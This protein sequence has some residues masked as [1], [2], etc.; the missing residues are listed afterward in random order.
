MILGF[1]TATKYCSVALY[2][3]GV[4]FEQTD[5]APNGHAAQLMPMIDALLTQ[6]KAGLSDIETIVV[7][8]GPGSFTGLRI[9]I[10]T[11]L[12]LASSLQVPLVGVSSLKAR[13]FLDQPT[14]CPLI[15]ARRDRVYA[16]CFGEFE[17]PEANLPFSEL[18]ELIQ[19]REVVF[20]GED[21]ASFGE[22]AGV[23]VIGNTQYARGVITAYLA[24]EATSDVSPR[25]LRMSQ[26]EA[27]AQGIALP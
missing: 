27:E 18:M 15:D 4:F 24:G 10:A 2:D 17:L 14:V 12:G 19:G 26:A 25:Y 3:N 8:L 6:A 21:I 5:P 1:D 7:S 9:G 11:A 23:A 13:S 16:A 20:T 22:R